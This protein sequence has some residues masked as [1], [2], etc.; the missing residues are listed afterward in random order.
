MK[1]LNKN[2]SLPTISAEE[3]ED[4]YDESFVNIKQS[5]VHN[6]KMLIVVAE[7]FVE[8]IRKPEIK[9]AK[10]HALIQSLSRVVVRDN[11][12]RDVIGRNASQYDPESAYISSESANIVRT[13]SFNS[14]YSPYVPMRSGVKGIIRNMNVISLTNP[15]YLNIILE[16]PG[17]CEFATSG[18]EK[19][20]PYLRSN[21]NAAILAEY[22]VTEFVKRFGIKDNFV[23]L[24]F[25]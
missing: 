19:V 17:L 20:N 18:N 8:L 1:S 5:F 9:F 16:T 24:V 12:T 23:E 11:Y 13:Q 14:Y 4:K 6:V 10:D 2:N 22:R 3:L 21:I 15:K 7:F 25:F